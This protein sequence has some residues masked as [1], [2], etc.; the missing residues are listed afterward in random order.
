M[1]AV[2]RSNAAKAT[3]NADLYA[4]PAV[5]W[6]NSW[7][8]NNGPQHRQQAPDNVAL[9]N[10]RCQAGMPQSK[11]QLQDRLNA[12]QQDKDRLLQQLTAVSKNMEYGRCEHLKLQQEHQL[13]FADLKQHTSIIESRLQETRSSAAELQGTNKLLDNELRWHKSCLNSAQQAS[14]QYHNLFKQEEHEKARLA[15]Q[16]Q[17]I[18]A[19][20]A[21]SCRDSNHMWCLAE[22]LPCPA[23]AASH[24]I[25][26][27]ELS[28][29]RNSLKQSDLQHQEFRGALGETGQEQEGGQ[30]VCNCACKCPSCQLQCTSSKTPAGIAVTFCS[31]DAYMLPL[32]LHTPAADP[33]NL[34]PLIMHSQ[35]VTADTILQSHALTTLLLLTWHV[36][37]FRSL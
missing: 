20:L 3:N 21:N 7:Q 4:V 13:R 22:K 26:T 23:A 12:A 29:A 19:E 16:L 1:L 14:G 24:E 10:A 28:E 2:S 36:C 35:A 17:H 18:Q 31:V 8:Q 5:R 33:I 30:E 32:M 37:V 27:E 9:D 34:V 11:Q 25:H 6:P 15:E